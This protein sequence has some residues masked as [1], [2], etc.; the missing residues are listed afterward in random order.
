MSEQR[1][2]RPSLMALGRARAT[3]LIDLL[4]KFPSP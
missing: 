3:P 2:E 1:F 4:E